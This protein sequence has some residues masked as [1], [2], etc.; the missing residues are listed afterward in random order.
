MAPTLVRQFKKRDAE[1]EKAVDYF[2]KNNILIAIVVN[3]CITVFEIILGLLSGSMALVSDAI[4][5]FSDVGAITLSWWGEKISLRPSNKQKTYGYKRAEILI[6]FINSS[7]LLAVIVFILIESV[8]R[9]FSPVEVAGFT[10]LI[11]ALIALVGNSIAMYFLE[12]DRHKN[13]NLKSAWLHSL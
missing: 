10:M 2:M 3:I 6:A 11:V 12:K 4:H 1:K 8:K 5:N 13:L 9:L 7:V